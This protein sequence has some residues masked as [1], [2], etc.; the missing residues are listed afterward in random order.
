[1][2]R[3][4]LLVCAVL[5]AVAVPRAQGEHVGLWVGTWEGAGG[6]GG[7]ELTLEKG[8]ESGLAGSVSV[9]G[10]PTYKATLRTVAI[11]GKKMTAAYDFPP[12]D[13]I[14][15]VLDA[16]VDGSTLKGAWV[17]RQK[18]GSEVASGTWTVTKKK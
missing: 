8:K 18:G 13:S 16:T 7:F 1:M 14:E 2:R 5:L 11:D 4:T 3:L 12:D 15:V 17:A 9:T 10:E 6:N